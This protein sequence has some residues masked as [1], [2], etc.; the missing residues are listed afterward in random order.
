M[1]LR[2]RDEEITPIA[3]AGPPVLLKVTFAPQER[4]NWCWAACCDMALSQRDK[5]QATQ[6]GIAK[7]YLTDD[8]C[9]QQGHCDSEC[10]I[11]DVEK[12]FRESGLPATQFVDGTLEADELR[13]QIGES[14]N[15]VAIGLQGIP[16]RGVPN[17]MVL[18]VGFAESLF[19][20]YDPAVGEGTCTFDEIRTDSLGR[21]WAQTWK[22]LR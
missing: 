21:T 8:N 4:D 14:K 6:C 11:D 13:R 3:P 10:S 15:T 22:D 7:N 5:P 19:N 16:D 2:K 18:V 1:A 20:V 17:H 12:V 9:C